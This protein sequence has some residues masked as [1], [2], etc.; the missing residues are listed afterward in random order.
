MGRITRRGQEVDLAPLDARL[1]TL[2]DPAHSARTL[3][4]EYWPEYAIEVDQNTWTRLQKDGVNLPSLQVP[5]LPPPRPGH[6]W[7]A[8]VEG[9]LR[10]GTT[11]GG[12]VYVGI[13]IG[14]GMGGVSGGKFFV[15]G[16]ADLLPI[17]QRLAVQGGESI[18]FS[19]YSQA[20]A[21]DTLT[22]IP[23]PFPYLLVREVAV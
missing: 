2:E 14:P 20:P 15:E 18:Y 10:V 12:T 7:E 23:N 9:F 4:A 13:Q 21:G 19:A 6:R 17:M 3:Q 22:I 8:Q 16:G 11:K 5:L 1:D